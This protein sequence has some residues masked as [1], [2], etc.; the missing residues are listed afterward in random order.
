MEAFQ[1]SLTRGLIT[2]QEYNAIL[3]IINILPSNLNSIKRNLPIPIV[4]SVFRPVDLPK[5]FLKVKEETSS[6]ND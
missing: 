6:D 1:S 5:K 2:L 3:G 4:S